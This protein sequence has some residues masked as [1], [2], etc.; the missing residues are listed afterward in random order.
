MK[1]L[2]LQFENEKSRVVTL[3]RELQEEYKI[4]IQGLQGEASVK[5]T[6]LYSN[7]KELGNLKTALNGFK[8][9]YWLR[10]A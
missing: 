7:Q 6:L 4:I 2:Q 9:E 3:N 10:L 5:Q 1:N 8:V